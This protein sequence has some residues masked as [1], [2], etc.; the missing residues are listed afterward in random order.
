VGGFLSGAGEAAVTRS[1]GFRL[2]A[3]KGTRAGTRSV[4][5]NEQYRTTFGFEQGHAYEV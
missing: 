4:R 1:H 3:L 5:I 2:E